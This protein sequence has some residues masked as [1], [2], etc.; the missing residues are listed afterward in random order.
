MRSI[1]R[2]KPKPNEPTLSQRAMSALESDF[3]V[4]GEDAIKKLREMRPD[5]YVE[6]ATRGIETTDDGV[7]RTRSKEENAI[8]LLKQMGLD[9]YLMTAS[10]VELVVQANDAFVDRLEQI[11]DEAQGRMQ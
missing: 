7:K 11:R 10:I 9:E 1:K 4:H 6:L 8:A 5:R 2:Q 3:K